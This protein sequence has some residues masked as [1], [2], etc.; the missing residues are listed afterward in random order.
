MD[1]SSRWR[2]KLGL[3]RVRLTYTS[4][5][6]MALYILGGFIVLSFI[7][8]KFFTVKT[9]EYF[10]YQAMSDYRQAEIELMDHLQSH[11]K[12]KKLWRLLVDLRSSLERAH[13]KR[14]I[15]SN[16][17]GSFALSQGLYQEQ[18]QPSVDFDTF[19]EFIKQ[20]ESPSPAA[21]KARLFVAMDGI[22]L[23]D[24][25]VEGKVE[26]AD[27]FI[28]KGEAEKALELYRDIIEVD[29]ANAE[30]R[31]RVFYC[32]TLLNK[33]GEIEKLLIDSEWRQYAKHR[34]LFKFYL[35]RRQYGKMFYHLTLEQYEWFSLKVMAACLL[36][37]LCW[38]LFLVHLG[39]AW[40]WRKKEIGLIF[41]ALVLGMISAV[42]CLGVVVIEDDLIGHATKTK[43]MSYNLAYFVLGV[44]LREE[45][46]KMLL[47]APLLF[48]LKHEKQT[49]KILT[50][51]SLVGLGFAIEENFAYFMRNVGSSVLA[52][53]FLTANFLHMF[54]TSYICYYLTIAVQRGGKAWDEF[55]VVF[56]K[57]VVAH[58]VYDFLLS[59]QTM[60]T[61]GF[62]FFAMMLL[63]WLSMQY[64]HL[65]VQTA[66]P[67]HRYVSLTRIFSI[68]LC[69]AIGVNLVVISSDIGVQAG[70]KA[71]FGSLLNSALFAYMFFRGFNEPV[72][73]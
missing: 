14:S 48:W 20:V 12:D 39:N 25:S 2:K 11:P 59:D 29:S 13:S 45:F 44:G 57:M 31:E 16:D 24:L 34:T 60:V 26:V 22:R 37:G 68:C 18:Q 52:D 9:S 1:F 4:L 67:R 10:Q 58:G 7:I 28:G 32:L 49:Y 50:Y 15:K 8:G 41:F 19:L 5:R 35:E 51:C 40:S 63:V 61:G 6:K 64:I 62:N 56:I 66:P 70:I 23:Q 43:T 3:D 53:R 33:T 42:V 65:I 73:R 69:V 38:V 54:L 30:A 71:M 21:L 55:T 17:D 72:G 27:I 47:F 36:V 46:C